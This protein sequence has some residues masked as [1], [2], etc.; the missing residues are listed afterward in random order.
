MPHLKIV[1]PLLMALFLGVC[2]A[3][4]WAQSPPIV[5]AVIQTSHY[6]P[7]TKT[8]AMRILNTSQKEI[9]AYNISL[10]LTYAD[11]TSGYSELGP[12]FMNLVVNGLSGRFMAGTS[13]DEVSHETKDVTNIK[14]VLDVVIYA[15][16]TAEVHN[17]RAFG[18]FLAMRQGQ[19]LAQQKINEIVNQA[20]ADPVKDPADAAAT[21]LKRLADVLNGRHDMSPG[22]PEAWV[23]GDLYRA[24]EEIRNKPGG[25]A[26]REYLKQMVQRGENEIAATKPHTQVVK[27][28]GAQ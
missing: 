25:K 1:R 12:D 22:N 10:T 16:Q 26:D 24:H 19:V 11:G 17:D 18:Q 7:R 14:A 27:K 3:G 6:D 23:K 13:H 21:E 15:D 5:G 20:L 9:T 2:T 4:S 8:V 28:V